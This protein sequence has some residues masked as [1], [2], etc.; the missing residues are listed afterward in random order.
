MMAGQVAA[1]AATGDVGK[2]RSIAAA[3][4][5]VKVTEG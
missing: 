5:R 4:R 3:L 1:S 2:A